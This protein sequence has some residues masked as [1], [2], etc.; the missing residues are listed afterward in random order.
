MASGREPLM[1]SI[2]ALQRL[3]E[4]SCETFRQALRDSDDA[5]D[6]VDFTGRLHELSL[7][8]GRVQALGEA[9]SLLAGDQTWNEQAADLLRNYLVADNLDG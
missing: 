6:A 9:L 7:A 4:N 8:A 2:A 3:Y 1:L 5:A